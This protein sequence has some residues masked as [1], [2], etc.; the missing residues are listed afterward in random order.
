VVAA[1]TST[2]RFD[3][4][5]RAAL[6]FAVVGAAVAVIA[7]TLAGIAWALLLLAVLIPLL[8]AL[9]QRP[10]R[11]VLL[12]LALAPFDGLLLITG[13][14][15]FVDGWKEAL[16]VVTLAATFLCPAEARAPAGRVLPRWLPALLGMLTIATISAIVLG[17]DRALYGMKIGFFYLLAAVAI[18]RC[19][20]GRRERDR[21]ITVL[22][23]VG[24]V[25]AIVG[26]AQ[27]AVGHPSL[28][29]LGYEY[30]TVIRFA[31][32]SLRSFSTFGQPFAFALFLMVVLLV[33]LAAALDDPQRTR[34]AMFMLAT[35]VL[36]LSMTLTFVRA[37]WLGLAVGLLYFG[38]RRH[39]IVLAGIPIALVGF[40]FVGSSV[41][42]PLL[43]SSSLNERA[44]GWSANIEQVQQHPFGAG[45]GATGAVAET[46]QQ[47]DDASV[48]HGDTY[49][50]DNFYFKTVYELGVLGLWMLVLL[51]FGVLTATRRATLRL[52]GRDRSFAEG[53]VAMVLAAI[54]ASAVATYFEIFPMD[55]LF[56]VLVAVVAT[57]DPEPSRSADSELPEIVPSA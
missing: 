11:G 8:L 9:V 22:M 33:G 20:L 41:A 45:I 34:N 49:Q 50:P 26:L 38:F 57:I 55:V 27:Q 31:G 43:S 6:A 24:F 2:A 19:P 32:N 7:F 1:T 12:L 21:L 23:A 3:V 4:P 35:P 53:V 37:A 48:P 15:K 17:G 30:N 10:Q 42:D 39:R 29:E 18:W 13:F 5:R 40:L 54:A 52:R 46:I 36:V 56:W 28:A 16:V 51:L 47:L 25:T 14:P 44:R